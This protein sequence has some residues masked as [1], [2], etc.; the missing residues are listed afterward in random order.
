MRGDRSTRDDDR[1]LFLQLFAAAQDVFYVSYQGADPRDGSA[2]EPS[3]LVADLLAAADAQHV[4]QARA[5]EDMVVRHP[6]QPF[7]PAAFGGDREPRRF[8]YPAQWVPAAAPAA[9]TRGRPGRR[10]GGEK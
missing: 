3:V 6:L 7:A 10:R 2:R 9:P 4:P 8:A 5:G 1:F